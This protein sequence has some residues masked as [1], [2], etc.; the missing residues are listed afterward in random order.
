MNTRLDTGD[1]LNAAPCGFLSFSDDGVVRIANATLLAMLDYQAEDVVGHHVERLFNVGTRI[2]YQTHFF[3]LL[4]LHGRAEEVFLL[5]RNR[6]GASVGMLSYARRREGADS[7]YD[8]V[9]V[10]VK[11]RAKYEDELLRAKRAAE[12]SNAQLQLQK[13]DLEHA[14]DLLE[15]QA[16]ELEMQQQQLREQAEHLEA[17]SEAIK[18]TNEILQ[19]RSDEAEQLRVAA[20]DANRAKSAFLAMMSHELR[21]PLNAIGGYLQILELGI[22]GPVSDAQRDILVRLD[23]SSRHLLRLINEVLDL[24]RIE[25]GHVRYDIRATDL[26]SIV[27]SVLPIAEQLFATGHIG[28]EGDVPK[29]L[30]VVVDEE[31]T[32]QILLNLLGNAAKFTPE[33]GQVRMFAERA[34]DGNVHLHIQDSGIGIPE[35]QLEAVFQPFVQVDSSR[36]RTAEGSGLGL[37][38]SRDL[39][40]GMNG[41]L[42]V[43]SVVGEGSTFTLIMVGA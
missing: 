32:S 15:S 7:Y 6:A 37:A 35:H 27:G 9:L 42:T 26:T 21:T 4:R 10:P 43:R 38:I 5:M 19:R 14:N 36:T 11:E 23:K 2:F 17:A 22:A 31:K 3:P 39:A 12:E 24:A 1:L 41:E 34:P 28:F 30:R 25:A 18:A 29:D 13:K 16:I 8:C 40:R 20:D 33:G